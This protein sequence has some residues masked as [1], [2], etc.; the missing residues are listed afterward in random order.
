MC[1]VAVVA[2]VTLYC[3]TLPLGP[4]WR[5][6]KE[7]WVFIMVPGITLK[8][9]YYCVNNGCVSSW[10]AWFTIVNAKKALTWHHTRLVTSHWWLHTNDITW[11]LWLHTNDFIYKYKSVHFLFFGSFWS[12]LI[13]GSGVHVACNRV[14][15]QL[16]AYIQYTSVTGHLSLFCFSSLWPG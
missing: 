3:Y 2:T 12:V 15:Q 11:S 5:P 10:F 9:P 1:T 14:L 7:N 8:C 4:N 16:L 6:Q 13:T